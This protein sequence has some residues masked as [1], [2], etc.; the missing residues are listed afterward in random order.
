MESLA[1]LIIF[2]LFAFADDS[3]SFVDLLRFFCFVKYS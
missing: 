1:F 3:E 2:L